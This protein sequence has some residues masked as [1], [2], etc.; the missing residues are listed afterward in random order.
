MTSTVVQ[1]RHV[2]HGESW[3]LK[4]SQI[5]KA[6]RHV[7]VPHHLLQ[8]GKGACSLEDIDGPCVSE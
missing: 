2:F 4:V 1:D 5:P 7:A 6:D 8:L 3:E